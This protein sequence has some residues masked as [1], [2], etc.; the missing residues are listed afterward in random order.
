MRFPTAASS[1]GMLTKCFAASAITASISGRGKEP[2]S[3]VIV[4]CPLITVVTPSSSYTSP[5]APKPEILAPCGT[6]QPNSFR[7][8]RSDPT[9]A[10]REPK[11]VRRFHL[12]CIGVLLDFLFAS[13]RGDAIYFHERIPRQ[14]RHGY[15]RSRGSAVRKIRF[16]YFVHAV[17]EVDVGEIDC[18]LQ[19]TVHGSAPRFHQQLHAVHHMLGV[20]FDVLGKRLASVVRMRPLAGNVDQAVVNDERRDHLRSLGGLAFVTEFLHAAS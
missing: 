9:V 17:V 19:N 5:E 2:P 4:P 6:L 20:V 1:S 10:P 3:V 11:N 12:N 13:N 8:L 16:K 7:A 14:G 18:E 15:R